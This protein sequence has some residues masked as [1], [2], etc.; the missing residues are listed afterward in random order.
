ML[1]LA[2]YTTSFSLC[3]VL[4]VQIIHYLLL[5][6]SGHNCISTEMVVCPP[7]LISHG[8]LYMVMS[9]GLH[10]TDVACNWT[11]CCI[12]SGVGAWGPWGQMPRHFCQKKGIAPSPHWS[13]YMLQC[14]L[15]NEWYHA[16]CWHLPKGKQGSVEKDSTFVCNVCVRTRRPRLDG[17][18]SLLISLKKVPVVITDGAGATVPGGEGHRLAEESQGVQKASAMLLILILVHCTVS[19]PHGNHTHVYKPIGSQYSGPS[20][21]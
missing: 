14:E 21:Q 15:C 20:G 7:L 6:S 17:L 12:H 1:S 18:V 5:L 3:L 10:V 11:V 19:T 2:Y 8:L 16:S 4:H 9:K 13:G